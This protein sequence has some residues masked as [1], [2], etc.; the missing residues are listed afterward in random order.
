M[1]QKA[2]KDLLSS[3][4]PWNFIKNDVDKVKFMLLIP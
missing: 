2:E 1:L 4:K 3:I